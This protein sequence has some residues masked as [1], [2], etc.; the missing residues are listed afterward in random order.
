[1]R[2][3]IVSCSVCFI[4]RVEKPEEEELSGKITRLVVEWEA[5]RQADEELLQ[6]ELE[7]QEIS[8]ESEN[9]QNDGGPEVSNSFSNVIIQTRK[10]QFLRVKRISKL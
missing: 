1:V 10:I 9:H 7:Q 6:A 5:K 3:R 2:C 8:A 4:F